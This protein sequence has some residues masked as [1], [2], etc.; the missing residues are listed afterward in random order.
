[1][2]K[3]FG[4]LHLFSWS[5][6][7]L[8]KATSLKDI[9]LPIWF[10]NKVSCYTVMLNIN[11]A[12]CKMIN[13]QFY[14]Y[15]PVCV[16]PEKCENSMAQNF[17]A[18]QYPFPDISVKCGWNRLLIALFEVLTFP[19]N[20][21][22]T[23]ISL[24]WGLCSGRSHKFRNLKKWNLPENALLDMLAKCGWMKGHDVLFSQ[25]WCGLSD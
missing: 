4:L 13:S 20:W 1:M 8:S 24:G 18:G 11:Y 19:Q 22:L 17:P 10:K 9:L 14:V 3:F 15:E 25:H 16:M 21:P 6:V 12:L 2:L 7:C 23:T 5:G